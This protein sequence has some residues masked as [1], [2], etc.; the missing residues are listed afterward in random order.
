MVSNPF[1]T[2]IG[3]P[4]A[5]ELLQRAIALDRIAPAYLFVGPEG[6][7][8]SLAVQGFL[9]VLVQRAGRVSGRQ[10][11]ANH[12][13]IFWV[14][15]TY[16]QSGKLIPVSKIDPKEGNVPKT[17]PQIRVEQIRDLTRFS[18]QAPLEATRLL[19][20]IDQAELMGE[21]AANGLLKTLEEPG[22]GTLILLATTIHGLLPTIV[23]RCQVI[24]FYSLSQQEL[25]AILRSLGQEAVLA[26]PQ[27]LTMAQGSPGAAIAHW[28]QLERIGSDLIKAC[29]TLPTSPLDCL[30]LAK[31]VHQGL[32]TPTQL[33]LLDYLQHY[34]WYQR[35]HAAVIQVLEQTK[36]YLLSYVQ[37][38]LTWEM[39]WLRVMECLR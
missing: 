17:R 7:G 21:A 39:T 10:N 15:P 30:T 34:F 12:P 37:P 5:V 13:D 29:T 8:R 1:S 25:R 2:L 22:N 11:M 38:Q 3:Q 33:W 9:Q 19:M 36:S 28:Q 6:V 14:E 4:Q 16:T 35:G 26:N 27:V 24:P 18:Q 23:S 32:D 20:V 31:Q